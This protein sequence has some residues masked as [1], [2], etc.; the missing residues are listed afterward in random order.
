MK[1]T[2]FENDLAALVAQPRLLIKKLIRQLAAQINN[3]LHAGG[4]CNIPRLCKF[5]VE[6]IRARWRWN[7]HTHANTHQAARYVIKKADR[8]HAKQTLTPGWNP[9]YSYPADRNFPD[10]RL[11]TD[12]AAAS[13]ID[14]LICNRFVYQFANLAIATL[15]AGQTVPI[16]NLGTFYAYNKA[17]RTV[18]DFRTWNTTNERLPIAAQ[19]VV[20]FRPCKRLK[21]L[22]N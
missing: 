22:V 7:M 4:T 18:P 10:C 14:V 8:G 21:N 20:N 9:E 2:D 11:A 19:K 12:I 6:K 16:Q 15:N 1:Q 3:N 5:R 17:A 13:G